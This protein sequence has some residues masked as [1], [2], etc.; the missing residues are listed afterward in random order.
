LATVLTL[1][2]SKTCTRGPD[3][4]RFRGR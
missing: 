2:C 1:R 3:P 4:N